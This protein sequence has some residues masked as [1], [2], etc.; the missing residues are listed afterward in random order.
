[1]WLFITHSCGNFVSRACFCWTMEDGS[2]FSWGIVA[3]LGSLSCLS[4]FHVIQESSSLD[5]YSG[6]CGSGGGGVLWANQ[7]TLG[8]WGRASEDPVY[9]KCFKSSVQYWRRKVREFIKLIMTPEAYLFYHQPWLRLCS[10][11]SL[12][13]PSS[14]WLPVPWRG[15]YGN[16]IFPI[17]AHHLKMADQEVRAGSRSF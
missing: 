8:G 15:C 13:L 7:S 14:P 1:M 4:G 17:G 10:R 11:A 9:S 2:S 6:A 3:T 5:L 12:P 16:G